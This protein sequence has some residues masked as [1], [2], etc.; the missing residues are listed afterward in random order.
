MRAIHFCEFPAKTSPN[1]RHGLL[2]QNKVLALVDIRVIDHFIAA[3]NTA[4]SCAER[5][6]L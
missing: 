1:N 2:Q 3:G 6:W 4:S 5:G